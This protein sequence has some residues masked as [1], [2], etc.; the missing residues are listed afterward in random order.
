MS[1]ELTFLGASGGPIETSTCGLLI[2]PAAL[3]YRE[4]L[5]ADEAPLLLVDAGLGLYA[6]ADVI[7][8]G[9][10]AASRLLQLYTD[11]LHP[12]EYLSLTP[13]FPF[14]DV[15]LPFAALQRILSQVELLLLSHPH[16]DHILALVLNLPGRASATKMSVFGLAF[17]IDALR[18]HVF[19]GVVWPDMHL[20]GLLNLAQ[21]EPRTE[22]EVSCGAF[23][24]TMFH[25]SHG[26]I[27]LLDRVYLSLAFLVRDTASGSRL[28]VF[29]DFEADC[30]LGTERNLAVWRHVAPYVV[31]GLLR[32]CVL[33]CSTHTVPAGTNLYGHLLPVHLM[34]EMCTLRELCGQPLDLDVIVT[35]VKEDPGPEDPRRKVL[36]ELQALNAELGLGLRLS[37]AVS[38]VL[39][40]V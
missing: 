2:K 32:C 36:A 5:D 10:A 14:R 28:L 3:S 19:N 26:R 12:H 17:T 27:P 38:G 23:A 37:V 16:L 20:L 9:P 35:H 40:V 8:N 25:L 39:V 22:F 1:F 18:T 15:G 30:V 21:V 4:V 11:S 31:D 6:L 33:E 7:Q 13:T 29:G 24:V 34:A